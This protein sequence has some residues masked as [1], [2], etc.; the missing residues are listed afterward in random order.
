M[1]ESDTILDSILSFKEDSIAILDKG[2]KY[3]RFNE[4]YKNSKKLLYGEEPVLGE[5][6][7]ESISSDID[8]EIA[9]NNFKRCLNGET[10]VNFQEFGDERFNRKVLEVNLYP[11]WKEGIS[12]GIILWIKDVTMKE[13]TETKLK[14]LAQRL[15]VAEECAQLGSWEM[16]L[17]AQKNWWSKNLF[18]LFYFPVGDDPPLPEEYDRHIHPEDRE[19]LHTSVSMMTQ[20]IIPEKFIFRTNPDLGSMRYLLPTY[21]IIKNRE[22]KIIKFIGTT[23]DIT[24][25]KEVELKV[26][27]LLKEKELLLKEVH[28]RIN[29]NMSILLSILSLQAMNI[30]DEYIQSILKEI[31]SRIHSMNVLYNKLYQSENLREMPV[32]IYF[33]SLMEDIRNIYNVPH[34][35]KFKIE[36][37]RITLDVKTLFMM[38]LITN[39]LITNSLKYAFSGNKEGNLVVR[40]LNSDNKLSMV[41]Y[42]DGNWIEPSSHK[43]NKSGFGLELVS[44]LSQQLKAEWKLYKENGTRYEFHFPFSGG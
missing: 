40:V 23:T 27:N 37:D 5:S 35:I 21:N 31:Q 8:I 33:Q 15:E 43:K 11:I 1:L 26:S 28:H 20:G 10:I 29:N 34:T 25:L 18:R 12:K 32:E 19:L 16:D 39:E 42:D 7:F 38:G 36:A 41:I 6:P 9:K 17:I 3:I 14:I 2:L 22:G 13:N 4:S 44:L 30:E 24:E